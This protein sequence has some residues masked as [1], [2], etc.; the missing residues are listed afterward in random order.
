MNFI[1]QAFDD[2]TLI[3]E[4][5]HLSDID[6]DLPVKLNAL[7]GMQDICVY[8]TE[9]IMSWLHEFVDASYQGNKRSG[10]SC[11]GAD[12]NA[13]S[14]AVQ[15]SITSNDSFILENNLQKKSHAVKT[16]SHNF[17]SESKENIESNDPALL[18][19]NACR[20]KSDVEWCAV[21][22]QHPM[23]LCFA[24]ISSALSFLC[25]SDNFESLR[26]IQTSLVDI[27][28]VSAC[29]CCIPTKIAPIDPIVGTATIGELRNNDLDASSVLAAN[30]D[31]Y[32]VTRESLSCL[33]NVLFCC[34]K[35]QVTF[36]TDIKLLTTVSDI[37]P[38]LLLNK[39]AERASSDWWHTSSVS[40]LLDRF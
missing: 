12:H 21:S 15:S 32:E 28:L 11:K 31:R 17:T 23:G 40:Q 8:L 1:Q 16:Q 3:K 29:I 33:A 36:T 26:E 38:L 39:F 35:A 34:T 30:E 10:V 24:V 6:S 9:C 19:M 37:T 4:F 25:S 2:T 14:F 5:S 20:E 27:G 13:G 22:S 7:A 18:L